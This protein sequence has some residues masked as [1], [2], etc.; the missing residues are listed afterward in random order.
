MR[1]AFLALICLLLAHPAM[2]GRLAGS[3]RVVDGDTLEV[4]GQM[5]RL[6][7]IDAPEKG[8]RCTTASG[9]HFPCG[10]DA[11]RRLQ[12]LVHGAAVRCKGE[13]MDRY[14]R[15][16]AVCTAGNVDL[17]RAMVEAGWALAF[18]KYSTRYVDAEDRAKARRSGLWAG[19]FTAPW[20]FRAARWEVAAVESPVPGCPIKGNISARGKI[21][22]TPYSQHYD[23]T[24]I[25]LAK[26]ERWFCSE[27]E[28]LDAG[29]RA[30]LN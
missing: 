17:N 12:A 22:H 27:R 9:Q 18:R 3:G 7:G 23:R 19:S 15:L 6:D 8:Q 25:N 1:A 29:W 14:D 28:A 11:A 2:A 13:E 21:Y 5:I 20:D 30:P 4:A 10:A 24:R 26:G 16:I